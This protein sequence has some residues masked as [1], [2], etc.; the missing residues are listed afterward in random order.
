MIDY[1]KRLDRNLPYE[2]WRLMKLLFS[3]WLFG[4]LIGGTIIYFFFGK[5]YCFSPSIERIESMCLY[6][7]FYFGTGAFLWFID[8]RNKRKRA[9]D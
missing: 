7:G 8:P 4:M 6:T 2:F 1:E 5:T 3:Y 9:D